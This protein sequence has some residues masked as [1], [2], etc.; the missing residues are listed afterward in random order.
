MSTRSVWATSPS[1]RATSSDRS[2]GGPRSGRSR[3]P[4]S[5]RRS[6]RSAD[7]SPPTSRRSTACRSRTATSDSAT[8]WSTPTPGGSTAVLDWELCTLGDPLAD[9]GY[10]GVYWS[11]PGEEQARANDP[12]GIEGFPTYADLLERYASAPDGP[13]EHRLLRR[14]LVVAARGDLRGRVRPLP[15]RGDGRPGDRPRDAERVQ[16]RHRAPRRP[17]R[18]R[19]WSTRDAG[20]VLRD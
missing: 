2:G 19:R 7:A 15:A 8:A 12:T 17:R 20:D 16:A 10:L 9:V 3:R 14:V 1:A 11:D 6:T 4:A 18:S 5:C 13:V